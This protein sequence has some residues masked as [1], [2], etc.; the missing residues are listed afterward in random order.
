MALVATVLIEAAGEP[1]TRFEIKGRVFDLI[2]V[3]EAAGA[4]VHIPRNDRDYALDVGLRMLA[5]RHIAI[6]GPEPDTFR[7]NPQ[8]EALLA[9]YA[10]SIAH[11]WAR[12]SQP[13]P[14]TSPVAAS[15]EP[16]AA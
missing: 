7:A 14:A 4:Y 15:V 8:E 10:N 5:L 16:P 12:Q 13:A 6:E 9:Y 1:R 2:R 11:L 3:L